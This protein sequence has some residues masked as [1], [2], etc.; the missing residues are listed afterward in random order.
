MTT[1]PPQAHSQDSRMPR[2]CQGLAGRSSRRD[3][4]AQARW[5]ATFGLGGLHFYPSFSHSPLQN[6]LGLQ[7]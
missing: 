1:P 3:G 7:R 5:G 4:H 2:K 6:P